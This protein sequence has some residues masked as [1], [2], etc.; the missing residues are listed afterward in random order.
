MG[1]FTAL[2]KD[3]DLNCLMYPFSSF[4]LPYD[5]RNTFEG[6]LGGIRAVFL[7][8][9]IVPQRARMSSFSLASLTTG[10]AN[11]A[12]W[13]LELPRTFFNPLAL[14]LFY[15]KIYFISFILWHLLWLLSPEVKLCQKVFENTSVLPSL[16]H[17]HANKRRQLQR[18]LQVLR[19]VIFFF[20]ESRLVN[21]NQNVFLSQTFTK[22]S[23]APF[24]PLFRSL[25]VA[26]GFL[27]T[28]HKN[29]VLGGRCSHPPRAGSLPLLTCR[30]P[31]CGC[32]QAP[33]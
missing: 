33:G 16:T 10:S 3:V 14:V 22:V 5:W 13:I 8:I 32:L 2:G 1:S 29:A 17:C 24:K 30:F 6:G 18:L 15:I 9:V 25:C 4:A 31:P 11:L 27:W 28:S 20:P 21:C 12:G 26:F 19:T 23:E 7:E